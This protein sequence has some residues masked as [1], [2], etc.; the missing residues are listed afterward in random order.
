MKKSKCRPARVPPASRE[1]PG[2]PRTRYTTDPVR[3][4][5][6]QE[7]DRQFDRKFIHNLDRR[8]LQ[9]S[10]RNSIQDPDRKFDADP[11]EKFDQSNSNQIA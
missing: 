3:P 4:R 1:E 9:D 11:T 2:S 7:F 6:H 5:T 8:F 10:D